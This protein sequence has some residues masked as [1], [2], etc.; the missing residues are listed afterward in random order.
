MGSLHIPEKVKPIVGLIAGDAEIFS[1]AKRPL[2]RIFRSRVDYESDIIDFTHTDYYRDQMGPN[3]KRRF[4]SFEKMVTP[5]GLHALKLK[6]NDLEK[7]FS[8]PVRRAIN[9]DPGYLS[10]SKLILFST[11]DYTHRTYLGKGIYAEVTL[12]YKNKTFNP[13]PW[14]YPDYKSKSY[15]D[16]FNRIRELI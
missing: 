3:L 11:K 1:K 10:L 4:L 7:R 16:I 8:G 12:F 15:I 9:I 14:T 2:E 5:E 6:T 13:W